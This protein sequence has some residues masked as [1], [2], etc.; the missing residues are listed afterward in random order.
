MQLALG[1]VDA[2]QLGSAERAFGDGRD[3]KVAIRHPD[4]ASDESPAR[5][6]QGSDMA[7][8][9]GNEVQLP[10]D[11]ASDAYGRHGDGF[12]IRGPSCAE[13]KAGVGR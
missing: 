5:G 4:G 10:A 8:N 7:V 12:A 3:E 11:L 1:I 9:D 6:E 13:L 2:L